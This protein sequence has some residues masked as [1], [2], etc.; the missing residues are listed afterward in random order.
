[1]PS[2][3]FYDFVSLL[4]DER[5][6]IDLHDDGLF[7][8]CAKAK[9]TISGMSPSE[10]PLIPPVA[11]DVKFTINVND[12]KKALS[13]TLF[14]TASNEARPELTGVYMKFKDGILIMASTD[15]YRL[16]EVSIKSSSPDGE[17]DVIVPQRT[18]SELNRVFSVFKDDVEASDSVS[19]ELANNQIVFHYGSV[20]LIS[21]TIE[22]V[23]P[24]YKMIIPNK[25]ETKVIVDKKD[26]QQAIKSVSLF[27]KQG[28]Y[29]VKMTVGAEGTLTL[30]AQ[31]SARGKNDVSLRCEVEGKEN[32]ITLNYRYV[33]DGLNAIT[34]EKVEIQLNDGA[35]PFVL[36]PHNNPTEKFLYIVMP[37]RQ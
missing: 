10:F 14:S 5:V 16:S 4:P 6:D 28:L 36:L 34:P 29:D 12:L 32:E 11:G 17:Y 8:A 21:R 23:F 26:L 25:F 1:M 27:S 9:T 15:S 7:I 22:G 13:Q 30:F 2:K 24:D 35:S 37:I 3:L 33:L 31:D 20:E 18:L 19:V